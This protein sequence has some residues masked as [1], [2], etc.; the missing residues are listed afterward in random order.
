MTTK[1]TIFEYIK[2]HPEQHI[3]QVTKATGFKRDQVAGALARL[4]KEGYIRTRVKGYGY[5]ILTTL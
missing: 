2:Q 5:V 3:G 4:K 1:Q